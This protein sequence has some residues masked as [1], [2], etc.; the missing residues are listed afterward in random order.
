MLACWLP[1][2]VLLLVVSKGCPEGSSASWT[3]GLRPQAHSLPRSPGLLGCCPGFSCC[4]CCLWSCTAIWAKGEEELSADAL[5]CIT[6]NPAS[7]AL[8]LHSSCA[9]PCRCFQ[10]RRT[11]RTCIT[12]CFLAPNSGIGRCISAN[13]TEVDIR[14][15][16]EAL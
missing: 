3:G 16:T 9:F 8:N 15:P 1:V 11:K 7:A 10:Q 4:S 13:K 6:H 2:L 12:A 14:G 5:D